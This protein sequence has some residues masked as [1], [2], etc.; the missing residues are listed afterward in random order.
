MHDT[1]TPPLT[2][3]PHFTA[4]EDSTLDP[5]T[6]LFPRA[7]LPPLVTRDEATERWQSFTQQLDTLPP[8]PLVQLLEEMRTTP[9]CA[10]RFFGPQASSL[11]A[12]AVRAIGDAIEQALRRPD[13]PLPLFLAAFTPATIAG[14]GRHS[15]G[16]Y[17]LLATIP[18]DQRPEHPLWEAWFRVVAAELTLARSEVQRR[19]RLPISEEAMVLDVLWVHRDQYGP[20]GPPTVISSVPTQGLDP[21]RHRGSHACAV[22]AEWLQVH[23]LGSTYLDEAFARVAT[24]PEVVQ[25]QIQRSLAGTHQQAFEAW[26]LGPRAGQGTADGQD[27]WM[28]V[29]DADQLLGEGE[30][31][32][33]NR[34]DQLPATWWCKINGRSFIDRRAVVLLRSWRAIPGNTLHSPDHWRKMKPE[35]RAQKRALLHPIWV[36][37]KTSAADVVPPDDGADIQ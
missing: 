6:G 10:A 1:T 36:A 12:V 4:R 34:K 32:L 31:Y 35:E 30:H 17:R 25:A 8:G 24:M 5:A 13:A 27:F 29:D 9:G 19:P 14:I 7:S 15:D 21:Q 22:I 26:V 2:N 28:H 18:C 11:Q 33:K 16:L 20:L 23:P 37:P 3:E